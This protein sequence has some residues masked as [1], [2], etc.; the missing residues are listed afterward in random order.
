MQFRLIE[1]DWKVFYAVSEYF[2]DIEKEIM[3]IQLYWLKWPRPKT[4]AP[5]IAKFTNLVD[6]SLVIITTYLFYLIMPQSK[7]EDS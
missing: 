4:K 7:E 2:S 1:I 5:G 6:R 3:H